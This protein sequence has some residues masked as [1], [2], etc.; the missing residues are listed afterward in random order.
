MT[1]I[2]DMMT[3][4]NITQYNLIRKQQKYI[5]KGCLVSNDWRQISETML[6]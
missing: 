5:K 2:K 6:Q 4:I 1:Y 3:S